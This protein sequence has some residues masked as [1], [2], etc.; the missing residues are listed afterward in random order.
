VVEAMRKLLR[1]IYGVLKQG[2]PFDPNWVNGH[3][4]VCLGGRASDGRRARELPN[5]A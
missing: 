1:L 4:A 3:R 2:K 5:T